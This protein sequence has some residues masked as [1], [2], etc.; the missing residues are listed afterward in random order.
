MIRT[1][2]FINFVESLRNCQGLDDR[3]RRFKAYKWVSAQLQLT[4]R[5]ELP[6]FIVFTL[7]ENFPEGTRTGFKNNAN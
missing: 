5:V 2:G 1:D 4:C 7:A 6:A 3:K